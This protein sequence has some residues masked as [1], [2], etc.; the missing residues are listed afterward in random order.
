M[1]VVMIKGKRTAST[2]Q[3]SCRTSHTRARVTIGCDVECVNKGS[4]NRGNVITASINGNKMN[5]FKNRLRRYTEAIV[6]VSS[7]DRPS[8]GER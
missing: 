6:Q 2:G 8:L 7:D 5:W 1:N 3:P 4:N